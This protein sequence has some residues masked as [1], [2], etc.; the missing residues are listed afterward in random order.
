MLKKIISL[1]AIASTVLFFACTNDEE[2]PAQPDWSQIPNP[3]AEVDDGL[4]KPA[5]CTNNIVAHRGGS[6]ECQAPDNSLASLRY[7]IEQGCY[8]SECD[9]YWTKDDNV[10]V[11]H[12]D[13]KCKINGMHP[14][15]HTLAEL[16]AG[17]GLS[18]GE[19]LPSLEEFIKEVKKKTCCT[20][21]Q[22]DIKNITYPSTLTEYAIAAA[23]RSCEIATEMGAKHFVM[24]V[25]TGNATV[26]KSAF[27][28]AKEAGIPIGWMNNRSAGEYAALGYDWANLASTHMCPEA[29]GKG[30]RTIDEFEKE[31]VALSIYN[32]DRQAGDG[33]AVSTPEAIDWYCM[34]AKRFK[35]LST[36]YPKWLIAKIEQATKVYDGIRSEA[37][38]QAFA[39]EVAVDPAAKRFQNAAGEVVLHNDITVSGAWRPLAD[40]TGVFDGNGKTLTVNYSGAHAEAGIFAALN[41]TVKNLRVAGSF[42]TTATGAVTLGAIAG[43]LGE[44]AQIEGCTNTAEIAMNVDASGTTIIGGIF[45][46][47]AEGNVIADNTN[48]G[49]ITVHRK[50]PS[51]TAVVGGVGGFA[52]SN[53]SGCVNEGEIRYSDEV[54]AKKA[55]YVGGVLGRLDVGK[56]YV[57]KDCRNEAAITLATAQVANNLL[58]GVVAYANAEKPETPNTIRNCENRGHI[59]ADAPVS[60]TANVGKARMGGICGGSAIFTSNVNYGTVE[61][62]GGKGASEFAI[63][64]ISGMIAHDATD[65]RNLGNVLNNTGKEN[66]LAHTGGLFGWATLDFTIESCALDAD[67]VST[68]LYNYDADKGTAADPT[69]ENSSCAGIL[70]G[71]IKSKIEVTVKSAQIYGR[72]T[73][74]INADGQTKIIDFTTEVPAENYLYGALQDAAS[75]LVFE[76]GAITCASTKK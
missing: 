45:G 27:V 76:S 51:E 67:V 55:M 2:W 74:T 42:T 19:Q 73:R 21:L 43:V 34:N 39:A 15:E 33:N 44:K 22:L 11:A 72:M 48:R 59:L 30:V 52:Y 46:K 53:V 56:G 13:G 25:C 4:L 75:K 16:R 5:A 3:D 38:L 57:V 7:A 28:Y 63:G 65:C 60:E 10:V 41:G 64:G 68:T 17:G 37:D 47:G 12:A 71:R 70:V 8:A 62:R 24:F 61:A 1:T 23:R 18:N 36:N 20:R 49:K 69:H 31:G 54:S 14:W 6:A 50:T 26:M 29:G 58:G 66:L 9:I 35:A 40:F 32:V